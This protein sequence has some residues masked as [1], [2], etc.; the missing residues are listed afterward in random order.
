MG[1]WR[2]RVDAA[3]GEVLEIADVNDYALAQATGGIY[4]IVFERETP[5]QLVRITMAGEGD[6]FPE[7]SG[8]HHRCSIRFMSWVDADNRA[9]QA[10]VDVPFVLTCCT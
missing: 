5:I 9:L 1:T 8:S 2:A 7:I 6:L 10:P 4:Q 3:T